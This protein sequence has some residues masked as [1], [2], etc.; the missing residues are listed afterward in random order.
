MPVLLPPHCPTI[1]RHTHTKYLGLG[2][3]SG[4]L[5]CRLLLRLLFLLFFFFLMCVYVHGDDANHSVS[6]NTH[7][8]RDMQGI[9]A[10]HMRRR[11]HA[12]VT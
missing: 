5:L 1:F 4:L 9:H 6:H 10:C 8:S 7:E 3:R 11:I 12:R 2:F